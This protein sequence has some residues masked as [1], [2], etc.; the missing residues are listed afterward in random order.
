MED[1]E[2]TK[3]VTEALVV[4]R[5]DLDNDVKEFKLKYLAA[6]EQLGKWAAIKE[7]YVQRSYALKDLVALHVTGMHETSASNLANGGDGRK[8]AEEE[9]NKTR[10][11]VREK[12]KSLSKRRRLDQDV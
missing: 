7:A 1:D 4:R 6:K 12:S 5:I 11:K 9:T 8:L 2:K 10:K 3:K